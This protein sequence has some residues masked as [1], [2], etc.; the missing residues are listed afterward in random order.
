M[1]LVHRDSEIACHQPIPLAPRRRPP[2]ATENPLR[3]A[4]AGP[5][6][7]TVA[8]MDVYDSLTPWPKG[9]KITALRVWQVLPLSVAPAVRNNGIQVPGTG[10]VNTGRAVLGTVPVEAD[11]SAHFIVPAGKEMF[12]QALDDKGLALQSMRSG[13]HFQPGETHACQG[14]HEPKHRAPITSRSEPLGM[15]RAPSRLQ[16]DVDG[17]DP[18]S[19]ARLVQPVLDKH[20]ADCHAKS[21]DKTFRLDS[22]PIHVVGKAYMDLPTTYYASYVNLAPQFGFYDYGG[23]SGRTHRTTPG[24]FGARAS[25]LYGLLTKGHY[26]VKLPPED[27][28]RLTV[29]LDSC[30]MFYGV[31]EKD[32]GE[33]QLRGEVVRPTL[34]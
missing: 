24:E 18:F 31:Y 12:F 4:A 2:V 28:H 15:R 16:P 33:A 30:S 27:L 19:Y 25:K 23:A 9:T 14:C 11:G 32:G 3:L 1:E 26:E 5:T 10:S 20:C 21:R 7:A 34:E 29:W 6:E 8:V 17:T 22:E 13:T